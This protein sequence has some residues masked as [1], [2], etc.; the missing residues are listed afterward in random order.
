MKAIRSTI[1]LI[2]LGISAQ[3]CTDLYEKTFDQLSAE[4][5]YQDETSVK[6]VVARIY[7]EAFYGY[8]EYFYY[9]QEFSADQ[10]AWRIWNGG[11][12]GYD[13]G[14]KFVLSTHTWNS[15]ATIIEQAWNRGWRAIGL[16]NNAL[17][18]LNSI[19]ASDLRMTNEQ[20]ASYIAEIQT[21]RAWAYYNMFEIWGGALPINDRV[22]SNIP[23]SADRDFNVGSRKVFDF[24]I[25]ELDAALPY[26]PT[27]SPNRMN[28]AMNRVLKA[29]LLL[30]AE[31][32]IG[33]NRYAQCAELCQ[34]ILN[35]DY[36][37]YALEDDYRRI[38]SINNAA[39]PEVIFAFATEVGQME[40]GWMRG[41]PFYP[42]NVND[43]F[44]SVEVGGWNCVILTPSKDNSASILDGG[45][46]ISFLDPPYNDKLGATFDRFH[47]LDI[48]KAPY[49]Y[50]AASN[51]FTGT[52][53]M[54]EMRANFGTGEVMKADADRDGEDLV[55]VDQVGTF[56]GHGRSLE[57]VMSSRW[58]ETNSGYRLVKYPIYPAATGLD[59]RNAD[60][61]EFRLAEVYL[62][63][64]E[65]KMRTGDMNGGKDLVNQVRQRYFTSADWA[66]V[67]NEPGPG[68]SEFDLDW[69]LSQW[70]LEYL[71][72]G[73]RR[74][75]DLRRFDKFTQ[76]Q[77]WFFGRA[78]E[79]GMSLDQKRDRKFEW[80]PLPQ[81]A[82]STNPG[83]VQVPGY[84]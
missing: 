26:L 53:L 35:G 64:A 24:I 13:E 10:I 83:L 11:L 79:H 60:E 25:T 6:G 46:P 2:I 54:G 21:L 23:P 5:Y 1:L 62:M 72:E 75:T 70:G 48:R 31:I 30:N 32:F 29:R 63:L 47:D 22:T 61:V 42:Y 49:I 82:L 69:L 56:K 12:W 4:I 58:G 8:I 52:L 17:H 39:S 73:R 19:N 57:V 40:G 20:L 7:N 76:G 14:D 16:S 51:S 80:F 45:S 50:D 44:S 65:C 36:G 66:T 9:L 78:T 38:F 37:Q 18:D 43:Y 84:E 71:N 74:R 3:S 41:Q 15:Q 55:Y 28:K 27:N 77:W 68:F 59:Y 34:S 67:Q 33:E 81:T